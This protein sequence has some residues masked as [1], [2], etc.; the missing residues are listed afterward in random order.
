MN[1]TLPSADLYGLVFWIFCWLGYQWFM[2]LMRNEISLLSTLRIY[3]RIWM[4]HT[5]G[6]EN[7]ISDVSLVNNLMQSST[8]FS[9]TTVLILGGLLAFLGTTGKGLDIVASI[10]FAA[11]QTQELIEL[12]I[13]VMLLVFVHA[14]LRFTWALRQFNVL[15]IVVGSFPSTADRLTDPEALDIAERA[16][17]LAGLAGDHFTQGLRSYYLAIP[18]LM[19]FASPWLFI[20]TTIVIILSIYYM[21]FHS[22]TVR[23]IAKGYKDSWPKSIKI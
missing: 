15:C 20:A 3:R 23:V 8:F 2:F 13:V 18:I 10:P 21:E 22:S 16:G 12:K 5:L 14:F 1:L 7:R 4:Y 19:W 9:S 17:R 6:R 11:K